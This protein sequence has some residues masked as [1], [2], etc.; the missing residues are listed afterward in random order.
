ME[1]N[2]SKTT[3]Y[4]DAAGYWYKDVNF[5]NMC[6][7]GSAAILMYYWELQ[8]PS[9]AFPNVTGTYGYF[10]EPWSSSDW[11]YLINTLRS[12]PTFQNSSKATDW[13]WSQASTYGRG[14]MVW[15][16]MVLNPNGTFARNGIDDYHY[17]DNGQAVYP[18]GGND[19]DYM[20]K[21][22]AWESSNHTNS[23]QYFWVF[24]RYDDAT[25]AND[26]HTAITTDIPTDHVPVQ[27]RVSTAYLTNWSG[28]GQNIGHA[29]SIIGYD[30]NAGTVTFIDTYGPHHGV[31]TQSRSSMVNGMLHFPNSSNPHGS[32]LDG[33]F[34]W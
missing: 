23:S 4:Y 15:L 19:P 7:D 14:Y 25:L 30:D 5:A 3:S 1:P 16:S 6:S 31:F 26:F 20:V 8:H 13:I 10:A 2:G 9:N 21:A 17:R 33:G 18:Q 24:V 22:L 28:T 34:V 12:Y 27:A 32:P 29:V 11:T